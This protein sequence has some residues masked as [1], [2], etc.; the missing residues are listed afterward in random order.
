MDDLFGKI[1]N[2]KPG[3]I[4]DERRFKSAVCIP[5][6]ETDEG[7][8]ILLEVRSGMIVHQPGDIC[9]PGGAMEPGETPEEAAV[10]ETCEELCISSGQLQVIGPTDVFRAGNVIIYPYVAILKDYE[11]SY[12]KDEVSE[13]FRLPLSFIRNTEPEAYRISYQ[14]VFKDDFPFDR[15]VGGRNYHWRKME[16]ETLFYQYRKYTIWGITAQLLRA[17]ARQLKDD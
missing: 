4:G 5:L 12:S 7:Y 6:I 14:P 3:V 10:R 16:Q 17:F 9:L 13:V 15:I 2:H 1:K 11:E 8:E